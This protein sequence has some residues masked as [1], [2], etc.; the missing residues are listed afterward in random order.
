MQGRRS[1]AHVLSDAIA[2]MVGHQDWP[3]HHSRCRSCREDADASSLISEAPQQTNSLLT[4]LGA[5]QRSVWGG[6]VESTRG[7]LRLG[8]GE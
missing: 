5:G 2:L 7:A 8:I 4:I 6:A 3:L 1:E